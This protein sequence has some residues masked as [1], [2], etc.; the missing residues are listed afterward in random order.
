M[1]PTESRFG[2]AKDSIEVEQKRDEE[3]S[4][5]SVF[6]TVLEALYVSITIHKVQMISKYLKIS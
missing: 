6:C 4:C 1:K 2:E 5:R 3:A